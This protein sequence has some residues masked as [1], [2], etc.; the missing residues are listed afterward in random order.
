MIRYLIAADDY[1]KVNIG[2]LKFYLFAGILAVALVVIL[3]VFSRSK[4]FKA[5]KRKKSLESREVYAA[6]KI[7]KVGISDINKEISENNQTQNES[8]NTDAQTAQNV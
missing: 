7:V 4:R 8:Q 2:D 1:I 5:H 3:V 6:P